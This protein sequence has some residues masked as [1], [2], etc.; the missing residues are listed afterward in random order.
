M[1]LVCIAFCYSYNSHYFPISTLKYL[2]LAVI[3]IEEQFLL[4]QKMLHCLHCSF[5]EVAKSEK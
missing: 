4:P 2:I 1:I 3:L 5:S